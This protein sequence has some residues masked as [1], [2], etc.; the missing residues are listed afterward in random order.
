MKTSL[1]RKNRLL[2]LT[3]LPVILLAVLFLYARFNPEDSVY[4]PK[5]IFHALTGLEC[6]GCGSQ[7]AIYQLLNGNIA[8]AMH[9]NALAVIAIPYIAAGIVLHSGI[10]GGPRTESLKRKL[11]GSKAAF[12]ALA[13]IVAFWIA[14]NFIPGI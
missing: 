11:Y 1:S 9:Y 14:R 5:C 4:F 3:V 10:A 12:A 6:P 2:L 8:E 7:R 13:I